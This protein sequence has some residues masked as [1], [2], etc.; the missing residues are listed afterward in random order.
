VTVGGR[1][2]VRRAQ[3]R[4][5]EAI[6]ETFSMPGA[7]AG[8]L[9]LP[10]PAA[11]AY[12]KWIDDMPQGDYML[13]AEIDGAVIGNLGLQAAGKSPR[14]RHAAHIGMS[15]HDAFH[16]RG[17]GNAL[18]TAALDLAD[19]WIAYTRLELSVYTDNAP[20]L[21]LYRK[22]GFAIEGTARSFALRNGEYVDAFMMA[23]L[24]PAPAH[25]AAPDAAAGNG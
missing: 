11:A 23:R 16:R 20:A 5:A 22:F 14:R 15:V 8:T 17:V 25:R 7:M 4:D 9:Q 13:V 24:A 3:A 2:V 10:F 6:A 21:A 12:A 19:N 1:T 18:M